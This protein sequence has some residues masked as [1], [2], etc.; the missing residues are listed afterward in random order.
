MK[1]SLSGVN[2]MVPPRRYGFNEPE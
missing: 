1:R 2:G